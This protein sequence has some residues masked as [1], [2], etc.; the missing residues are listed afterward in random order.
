MFFEPLRAWRIARKLEIHTTPKHGSRLNMAEIE[1]SVFGREC[2]NR[3]IPDGEN[4]KREVAALAAERNACESTAHWRF[5]T[6]DGRIKLRRLYP[7]YS[8]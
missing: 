8:E 4:L 2:L 7:S 3:R 5:T 6:A 1:I